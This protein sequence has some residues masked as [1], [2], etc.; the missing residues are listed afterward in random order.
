MKDRVMAE[1]EKCHVAGCIHHIESKCSS[2]T[3][4]VTYKYMVH[5]RTLK[6][7]YDHAMLDMARDVQLLARSDKPIHVK[8]DGSPTDIYSDCSRI[9]TKEEAL[10]E[11]LDKNEGLSTEELE[12]RAKMYSEMFQ[13][14]IDEAKRAQSVHVGMNDTPKSGKKS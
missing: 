4:K 12:A 3:P 11:E 5:F 8:S 14:R 2:G 13:K 7:V 10:Q 1:T 9:M 6:E